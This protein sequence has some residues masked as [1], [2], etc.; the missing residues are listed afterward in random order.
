[1]IVYTTYWTESD[2]EPELDDIFLSRENAIES[3][4]KIFKQ[5][6][7]CEVCVY[8][9]EITTAG[10]RTIRSVFQKKKEEE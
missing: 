9:E 8:A 10:R 6:N 4:E 7:I 5:K 3:V 2:Y 1:M